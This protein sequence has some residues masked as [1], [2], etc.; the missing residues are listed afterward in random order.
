MLVVILMQY[1]RSG[2]SMNGLYIYDFRALNALIGTI[3]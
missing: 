3:H 2:S 1:G